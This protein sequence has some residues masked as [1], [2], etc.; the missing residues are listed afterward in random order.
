M[1]GLCSSP[2]DAQVLAGNIYGQVKDETGAVIPDAKIRLVGITIGALSTTT[3]S[4]GRF[5]FLVLDSGAYTLSVTRKGFATIVREVAVRTGVSVQLDFTLP[6]AALEETVTITDATPIVDTS[7]LGTGTTL[8]QDELSRTPSARDPWALLRTIPGVLVD[9]DNIAGNWNDQQ[10]AFYGKGAVGVDNSFVLDGTNI[11]EDGGG[12]TSYFD[13]DAFQEISITTGGSDLRAQT[14]GVNLNFTTRRGT[15][16]LHGSA[17][18]YFTHDSLEWSNLPQSLAG[19]PRLALPDGTSS[20]KADHIRQIAD[21]GGEAGGPIVRDKLWIWVAYGH[22]DIRVVR[23]ANGSQAPVNTYLSNWN[24]KLNWQATAKDMISL[25]YF[26]SSKEKFRRNPGYTNQTTDSFSWDQKPLYPSGP[27]GLYKL[28]G[29][30]T[31]NPSWFLNATYTYYGTGVGFIPRGGTDQDG[32]IDLTSDLSI[33]SSPSSLTTRRWQMGDV[34]LRNFRP[35]LGG[36]QEWRFGFGYRHTPIRSTYAFSGSK[37]FAVKLSPDGGAAEVYRDG[38]VSYD[39]RSWDAYLGNTYTRGRLTVNAGLRYDHQT[40]S[41]LPSSASANPAFPALLPA[42]DFA[43]GGV[44]VHWDG[45]SPR[46]GVTYALDS[47]HRTVARASYARYVGRITASEATYD[48]P[49]GLSG[50]YLIY[51]W[52]DRNRDGFAQKDEVLLDEGVLY[53][54]AGLDPS[55]P[56]SPTSANRIDPEYRARHDDEIIVGLERELAADLSLGAAYTWRRNV[57]HSW[58][59]RI[60]FT[61]ADYAPNPPVTANGFTAQTFSPDPAKVAASKNGTILTNRPDYA[62]IYNGLELS[63]T[64][65]LSHRWMARAGVAYMDLHETFGSPA[66]IQNPTHTLRDPQIEGGQQLQFTGGIYGGPSA[67]WQV[68]AVGLYELPRGFGAAATFWARQG[69]LNPYS[70]RLNAGDD[71]F[72]SALATPSVEDHRL[73]NI[74]DLDVRLDK[75]VRLR[76]E[77]ALVLSAEL[78]NVFNSGTVVYSSAEANSEV[79]GRIYAILNPRIVR[80]GVRLTF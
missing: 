59:P 30:H 35:G 69:F 76:G 16:K 38:V 15:N 34:D 33:G 70:L 9:R 51:N 28:E 17:R 25:V 5:H 1:L 19:D 53:A 26:W 56:T 6:V 13:F 74:A 3:N 22:Q 23:L 46:L 32:A 63:L 65:R 73:A 77:A 4:Q 27:H 11:T 54:S 71:G 57:D 36:N 66:A 61:Q 39:A 18:G 78:F 45:L 47:R 31:F 43:G 62:G 58:K 37:L 42:L 10:S 50:S 48:S 41:D 79:L 55:N 44:G 49:I 8:M 14:G 29:S 67:R 52:A 68:S 7:K 72:V 21:Y 12:S 80:F 75:T 2:T 64:K 20:D 40:A 24:A 60:G